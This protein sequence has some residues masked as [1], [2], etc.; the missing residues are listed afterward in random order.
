MQIQKSD[1]LVIVDLQ[2]DFCPKGALAVPGGDEIVEPIN[3]ILPLFSC[4]VTT[5]D[6]HPP[7]HSSFAKQGGSWPPH[8]VQGTPGA[9]LHP[10]L[11]QDK[12]HLKIKKADAPDFDAYSG[13]EGTK[14]ARE[15]RGRNIERVFIV[16]L[17]TDYC[18]KQTALDA[19]NEG[20]RT[21]VVTD[22]VRAVNVHP[23]DGEKALGDMKKA[24]ILFVQSSEIKA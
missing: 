8:C 24:G 6:W 13:F 18:V 5:Q 3:Q 19:V 17:A 7:D 14:L 21:V 11:V 10:A 2:N 9:L 16:G 15:L 22:L 12:V 23:G 4:I 1:A 20:F